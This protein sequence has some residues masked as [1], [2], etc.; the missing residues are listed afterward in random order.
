MAISTVPG[1]ALA[2][3]LW[4]LFRHAN[5]GALGDAITVRD[6]LNVWA[7]GQLNALGRM[8][9]LFHPTLYIEWLRSIFGPELVLH[10]WSYPP[11]MVFV[12]IPFAM[13]PVVPGFAAWL[14]GTLAILLGMLRACRLSPRICLAVLL[15]PAVIENA[16][17][18]Q[19]GA[20][21]SA[22]LEG[23][24]L[25]VDRRPVL[26]GVLFGFLTAK[27]QIGLLVPVCLL[28]SRRWLTIASAV[29]TSLLLVAASSLAFGFSS[30][31]WYLTDVRT[32]MTTVILERPFG[33]TFQKLMA[34][35]FI[36]C[37][38][39]GAPLSLAYGVQ[40]IVTACCIGVIWLAWRKPGTD[41]KARMALTASLALLA[42]PYGYSYDTI[43]TAVGVAVLASMA[44]ETGFLPFEAILLA[45]GWVWPGAAFWFG[46]AGYPPVGCFT[47]AG[48]AFCAWRRL[49]PGNQPLRRQVTVAG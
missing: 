12:A 28:A 16:L 24:L 4:I 23:G 2:V 42:T 38:Y 45:V 1:I 8:D 48:V 25:L 34:T 7:A 21:T 29:V 13:L 40:A 6:Y 27:P 11:T 10:T 36:F 5:P 31:V 26:A 20:L 44:L 37:R 3:V 39:L 35:P 9:I 47:L 43:G 49:L 33:S 30:W 32:F 14:S 18:G 41:T 17:A 46:G 22:M 15:S 19:N